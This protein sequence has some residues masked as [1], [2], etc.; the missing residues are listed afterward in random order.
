MAESLPVHACGLGRGR[1]YYYVLRFFAL[2]GHT[3]G[4]RRERPAKT[5][6]RSEAVLK[7]GWKPHGADLNL[8]RPHGLA[9]GG[10]AAKPHRE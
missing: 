5:A 7:C 3:Q 6:A 4:A 9:L 10:P 2:A 8:S 1:R